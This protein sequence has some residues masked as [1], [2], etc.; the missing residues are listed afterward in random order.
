MC[1]PEDY[2]LQSHSLGMRILK[3]EK[4]AHMFDITIVVRSSSVESEA[5]K[6]NLLSIQ[7]KREHILESFLL[8]VV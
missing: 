7:S 6:V 2:C 5:F 1:C 4:T 8:N 3:F